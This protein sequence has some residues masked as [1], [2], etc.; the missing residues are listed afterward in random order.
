MSLKKDKQRVI[1]RG[2]LMSA[3]VSYVFSLILFLIIPIVL[4]W[5]APV[6]Q[7]HDLT[8]SYFDKLHLAPA[9]IA[10]G[11]LWFVALYMVFRQYEKQIHR[12]SYGVLDTLGK[13]SLFV[14]GLHAFLLFFIDMYM[15]PT[16]APSFV[17]NTFYTTLVIAIIY[18]VTKNRYIFTAMRRKLL[19]SFT[20]EV[21]P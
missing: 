5:Y 8:V 3:S 10:I 19:P 18:L 4:A 9:R 6:M 7:F 2:V 15:T 20:K 13:N 12:W 16:V 1:F 17:A 14:Y 21:R 11:I